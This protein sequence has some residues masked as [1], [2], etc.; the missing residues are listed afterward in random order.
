MKKIKIIK[1]SFTAAAAV[2]AVM[3]LVF[4]GCSN[5]FDRSD[6]LNLSENEGLFTLNIAGAG[7]TILPE[8]P[9]SGYYTYTLEFNSA[10]TSG[11]AGSTGSKYSFDRDTSNINTSIPLPEGIYTLTVK[12]FNDDARTEEIARGIAYQINIVSGQN[13]TRAIELLPIIETGATGT[14]SWNI[15]YPSD[16]KDAG[17][18]IIP[19][20]DYVK[21]GYAAG[22]NDEWIFF[23]GKGNNGKINGYGSR[24]LN[25]GYYKV[26]FGLL[27]EDETA[28]IREEYLHVYKNMVSDF[29]FEFLEKHFVL[30]GGGIDDVVEIFTTNIYIANVSLPVTIPASGMPMYPSFENNNSGIAFSD[31][32]LILDTA[33]RIVGSVDVPVGRY[34]MILSYYTPDNP[35]EKIQYRT[36]QMIDFSEKKEYYSFNF[37]D[38]AL[39]GSNPG[40]GDTYTVTFDA[41]GGYFADNGSTIMTM[42]VPAG[43]KV[44]EPDKPMRTDGW[45]FLGWKS[46]SA[47]NNNYNFDTPVNSNI[48]LYAEWGMPSEVN[49]LI[50][51]TVRGGNENNGIIAGFINTNPYMSA[52]AGTPV[53]FTVIPNT[54]FQLQSITVIEES[55]K[56]EIQFQQTP[57]GSSGGYSFTMPAAN[58]L[59]DVNFTQTSSGGG[60]TY[61]TVTFD[62]NGGYFPAGSNPDG[63]SVITLQI[64]AGRT[65]NSSQVPYPTRQGYSFNNWCTVEKVTSSSGTTT[66]TTEIKTPLN[67]N[68][69]INA[70]MYLFADWTQTSSGGDIIGT[71]NIITNVTGGTTTGVIG[72]WINVTNS[73]QAGSS[74]TFSVIPNINSGYKLTSITVMNGST[75]IAINYETVDGSDGSGN[76]LFIM[77][78]SDVYITTAFTDS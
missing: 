34:Y 29:S 63:S 41:N 72:G 64:E 37:S 52:P 58:V 70:D 5:Q 43:Q 44:N 56:T 46:A 76:Y 40:I 77:P 9:A 26:F 54:G 23:S 3:L 59:I 51:T 39:Y 11:S 7:R 68:N 16:V 19:Y 27:R 73:A 69:P 47:L 2:I 10:G 18:M 48:T 15:V 38:F 71:F 36:L 24:V 45:P 67:L 49:Y 25:T 6:E 33:M 50:T 57:V 20:D 75:N 13:T 32:N 17:V 61:Y 4:A 1:N 12:A 60:T 28:V 31:T 14:F 22:E 21:N 30:E 8:V 74:V 55:T 66:G 42:Q 78:S 62:A 65:I 35:S 53:T